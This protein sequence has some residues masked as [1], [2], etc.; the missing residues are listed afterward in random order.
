LFLVILI[1]VLVFSLLQAK[2]LVK[3]PPILAIIVFNCIFFAALVGFPVLTTRII[4]KYLRGGYM[5][6]RKNG[7]EMRRHDSTVYCPWTLFNVSAQLRRHRRDQVLLPAHTPAVPAVEQR[8]NDDVVALGYDVKASQFRFNSKGEMVLK[9]I[10]QVD[11]G[12]LVQLLLQIG[13]VL[14]NHRSRNSSTRS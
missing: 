6:L 4:E 12:E 9:N 11:I 3:V 8:W 2:P 10:Y 1:I 5:V 7:V 14:G 13:P